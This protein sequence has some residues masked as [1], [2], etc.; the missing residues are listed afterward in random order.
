MKWVVKSSLSKRLFVMNKEFNKLIEDGHL[1]KAD[2]I[3]EACEFFG[4]NY[5]N[6]METLKT[7]NENAA[8]GADN[9]KEIDEFHY[10]S[11]DGFQYGRRS[12]LLHG[13][14]SKYPLY[15]GW[16]YHQHKC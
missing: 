15:Y 4:I 16:C 10:R 3:E 12:L 2:T 9:G 11:D 8:K 5:E 13:F 6:M 1:V 14:Y 7:W